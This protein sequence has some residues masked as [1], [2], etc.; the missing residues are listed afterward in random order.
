MLFEPPA[1]IDMPLWRYISLARFVAMLQTRSLTMVPA[2]LMEDRFEGSFPQMNNPSQRLDR[3]LAGSPRPPTTAERKQLEA[4]LLSISRNLRTGVQLS[5]WHANETES[6][7][8]WKLYAQ[9]AIC[10][11]SDYR[12]LCKVLNAPTAARDDCPA[13]AFRV[14]QVSYINFR[15]QSIDDLQGVAPF[16]YKRAEFA[17][18]RE[19]RA[20]L[21]ENGPQNP[22]IPKEVPIAL[23]DLVHGVVLGPGTKPWFVDTIA[24]LLKTYELNIPI[25]MSALDGLVIP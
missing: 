16:M 1:R 19:V 21:L 6:V 17:H 14:G 13:G 15:T 9:D 4:D 23:A 8:M 24:G 3:A 12:S 22:P 2:A 18:E 5:C 20:V 7:A 11:M 10:L 25:N